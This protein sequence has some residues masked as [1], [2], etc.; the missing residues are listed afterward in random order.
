MVADVSLAGKGHQGSFGF[1]ASLAL[2]NPSF[3]KGQ[4]A[5]QEGFKLLQEEV[6]QPALGAGR[7]LLSNKLKNCLVIRL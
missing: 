3:M 5:H 2:V 7:D 1:S 6:T 4:P